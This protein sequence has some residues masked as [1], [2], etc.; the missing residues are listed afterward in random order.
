M[1]IESSNENRITKIINEDKD[2][3]KSIS[4]SKNLDNSISTIELTNN[5]DHKIIKQVS[6]SNEFKDSNFYE[7]EVE[8]KDARNLTSKNSITMNYFKKS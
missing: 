8:I 1:N 2:F 7:L 5:Y 3:Y 6:Q 4:L